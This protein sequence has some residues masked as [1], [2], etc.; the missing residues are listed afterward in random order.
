MVRCQCDL[1]K[2]NRTIMARANGMTPEYRELVIAL[3]DRALEAE[4]DNDYYRTIM[5]GDWPQAIE[6][7]QRALDKAIIKR[8]AKE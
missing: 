2:S 5:K 4:A 3:L 1:C 6:I 8:E 7:L